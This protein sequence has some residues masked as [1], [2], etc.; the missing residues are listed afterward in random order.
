ML[1]PYERGFSVMTRDLSA[2][3]FSDTNL[4]T[5][6]RYCRKDSVIIEEHPYVSG[7]SLHI[8]YRPNYHKPFHFSRRF[9]EFNL[10]KLHL[11]WSNIHHHK[12][13]KIVFDPLK[14]IVI[15]CPN[16]KSEN[17]EPFYGFYKCLDC[18][19]RHDGKE[20]S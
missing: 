6:K 19:M 2:Y 16:C 11:T 13:G 15:N 5:C 12:K 1:R 9:R 20:E 7:K 17:Q 18:E 4:E 3:S 8:D 10:F 14:D